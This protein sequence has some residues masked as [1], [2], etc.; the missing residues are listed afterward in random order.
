MPLAGGK[1]ASRRS[2]RAHSDHDLIPQPWLAGHLLISGGGFTARTATGELYDSSRTAA[3]PSEPRH[4]EEDP[5]LEVRA[6]VLPLQNRLVAF[7]ADEVPHEVLPPKRDRFA[8]TF[9][10]LDRDVDPRLATLVVEVAGEV[11]RGF[12]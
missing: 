5:P 8:C 12:R 1:E 7:W 11:L 3:R 2:L 4:R 9:W 6:E 10:Y